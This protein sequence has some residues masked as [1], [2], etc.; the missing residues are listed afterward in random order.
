[1]CETH[2]RCGS[3]NKEMERGKEKMSYIKYNLCICIQKY[4]TLVENFR[5]V[6][7]PDPHL[8]LVETLAKS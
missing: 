2:E 4:Q 5:I 8:I 3:L 7:K 6:F 1:M